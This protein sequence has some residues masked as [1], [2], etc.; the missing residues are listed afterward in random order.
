MRKQT[1]VATAVAISVTIERSRS[2]D[3]KVQMSD[4]ETWTVLVPR[5][6]VVVVVL[7]RDGDDE[8]GLGHRQKV[9]SEDLERG[10]E[11]FTD[12]EWTQCRWR[13]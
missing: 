4:P 11:T 5:G 7:G 3:T 8:D 1:A 2:P 10:V 6:P 12:T 13:R 9:P